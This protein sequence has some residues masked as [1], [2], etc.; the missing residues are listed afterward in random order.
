MLSLTC[1]NTSNNNTLAKELAKLIDEFPGAA[2]QTCCFAHITNLSAK[3]F[4]HLFDLLKLS[5]DGGE[6]AAD[7]LLN[8]DEV[9]VP[10]DKGWVDEVEALMEG[11]RE[12]LSGKVEP[13]CQV[14]KK[15][16]TI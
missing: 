1:D 8:D 12:T 16:G 5:K 14:L 15:V 4:L 2:A 7:S 13:V 9:V 10:L 6:A 3:S 11:E